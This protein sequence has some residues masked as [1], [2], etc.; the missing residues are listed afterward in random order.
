MIADIMKYS[1][2]YD[3][4]IEANVLGDNSIDLRSLG[5]SEDASEVSSRRGPWIQRNTINDNMI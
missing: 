4:R 2:S 1:P 5:D 3:D